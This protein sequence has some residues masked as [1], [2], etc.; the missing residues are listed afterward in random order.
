M[1][2][3]HTLRFERNT[4]S[5]ES[6]IE[7][8]VKIGWGTIEDYHKLQLVHQNESCQYF[9][10][11]VDERLAGFSKVLTDNFSFSIIVEVVISPDFQGKGFGSKLLDYT[12][13]QIPTKHVFVHALKGNE[14]F[15]LQ[16]NFKETTDYHLFLKKL[17]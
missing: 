8:Y 5:V 15:F 16:R 7:I 3:N 17:V 10:L 6:L 4:L 9:S 14:D 1:K 11:F 2:N 12:E 13:R